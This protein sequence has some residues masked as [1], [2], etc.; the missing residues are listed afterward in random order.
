MSLQEPYPELEE[1]LVAIGVAGQRVSAIDAS[2]GAA[3]NISVYIGWPLEV[4]RRFPDSEPLELPQPVPAL[5]G[6]HILVTGSGR[7][8]RDIRTDPAAN[9]G[10][11]YMDLVNGSQAEGLTTDELR[12]VV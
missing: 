6:K 8:L 12:A 7:R 1:F 2:E 3:G 10:Y 4:R 5:A 11:E 9:L